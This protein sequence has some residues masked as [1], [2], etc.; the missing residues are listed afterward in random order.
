MLRTLVAACGLAILAVPAAAAEKELLDLKLVGKTATYAWP[1]AQSQKE[2]ESA[3]E[4]LKA[5][6]KMGEKLI[7]PAPPTIDQVLRITNMGKEKV[8]VY[9]D[10]DP[11]VV[12]LNL[13]GPGV[14]QIDPG[15]TFTAELRLPKE[16]VLEPGKS[17]DVAVK[18]LADG[19]RS[20]SRY[21]Y[22]TA[23]GEYKLSATYQLGTAEGGKG[24]LL[25]SDEIKFTIDEPKK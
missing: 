2:F 7:W 10:G 15:Y 9:V 19:F 20:G 24:R 1:Y 18:W 5:K 21:L 14:V 4:E 12:T 17:H 11:N 16:V 23:P 8:A 13:K 22:L 25:K 6:K 3:L